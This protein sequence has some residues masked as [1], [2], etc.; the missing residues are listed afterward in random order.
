MYM[1]ERIIRCSAMSL[2]YLIRKFGSPILE[3]RLLR[4]WE[5]HFQWRKLS[6]IAKVRCGAIFELNLPDSIQTSIFLRGE[7]EPN[8]SNLI[9]SILR[10]GD[11]FVDVGA[12]IGWHTIMASKLV[13]SEGSVF[14]FEASPSIYNVL[15]SN[16]ARNNIQNVKTYNVAVADHHGSCRVFNA[17]TGN[18][19]HSTIVDSLAAKDGHIFESTMECDQL[20]TLLDQNVLFN[21]RLIKI[22]IEGAERMAIE[23]VAAFLGQFSEKSEWLIELSPEFS[24]NGQDDIDWIFDQFLSVGYRAFLI[25]NR[26]S[27]VGGMTKRN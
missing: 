7:W 23:G 14:A 16:L 20:C 15:L 22:D 2:G 11:V 10:H 21:A 19:G 17:P 5:R 1:R 6:L 4:I 8:I 13:G 27:A 26:Y 3:K 9:S 18:L 12:N 25:E 24:P